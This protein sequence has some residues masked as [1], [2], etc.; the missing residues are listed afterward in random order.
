MEIGTSCPAQT[1]FWLFRKVARNPLLLLHSSVVHKPKRQNTT[2][3][4]KTILT[5]IVYF[6][7]ISGLKG[8]NRKPDLYIKLEKELEL[9][10]KPAYPDEEIS[11]F[12]YLEIFQNGEK[13]FKDTT[14]TEYTLE[15]SLYPRLFDFKNHLELLIEVDGRPNKN[16]LYRFFIKGQK[17]D[18]IDT[19]PT[20]LTIPKD[21]DKDKKLEYAGFWDYGQVWGDSI[22]V[23]GYNPIVIYEITENGINLDSLTTIK[24]NTSI[25]GKFYGFY[26]N[27]QIEVPY[28][29]DSKFKKEIERIIN[30]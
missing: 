24:V 17:L 29:K 22:E 19:L 16:E 7:L 23:T 28:I 10:A 18:K 30:E 9:K 4:I 20:F 11:T 5:L 12:N 14:L 21:L 6:V 1:S 8:Q 25:Y 2:T 27:E 13:I 3:M 15:D 26:F